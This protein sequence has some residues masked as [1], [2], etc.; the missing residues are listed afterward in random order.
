MRY[1]AR[2][3]PRSISIMR[4]HPFDMPSVPPM[5]RWLL[6]ANG[7]GFLLRFAFPQYIEFLAL[8]PLGETVAATSRGLVAIPSLF[9]PWQLVTY[10]F[11]H[12]GFMH[13]FFNMFALW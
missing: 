10:G 7:I 8:W 5:I 1:P 3:V 9:E 2:F 12:A 4:Q 11:L 13:L 6:I